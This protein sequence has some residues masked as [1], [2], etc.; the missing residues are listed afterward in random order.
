[1]TKPKRKSLKNRKKRKKICSVR[2]LEDHHH[3]ALRL[4]HPVHPDLVDPLPRMHLLVDYP[5]RGLAGRPHPAD[6]VGHPDRLALALPP[7]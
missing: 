6:L 1:M 4:D 7:P 3:Q 5:V 2:A